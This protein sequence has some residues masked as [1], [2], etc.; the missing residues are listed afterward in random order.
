MVISWAFLV[1]MATSTI[2]NNLENSVLSSS[3]KIMS[4]TFL[5]E[6]YKAC[7]KQILSCDINLIT[8]KQS[9]LNFFKKI[10]SHLKTEN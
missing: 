9:I 1:S 8:F 10:V 6:L 3:Q 4:L 7:N 5:V 2:E